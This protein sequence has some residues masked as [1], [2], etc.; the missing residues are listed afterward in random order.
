MPIKKNEDQGHCNK[1]INKWL[2]KNLRKEKDIQQIEKKQ[3]KCDRVIKQ[4]VKIYNDE[5]LQHK[6]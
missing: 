4:V 5:Y 6:D 1:N 3:F 2:D